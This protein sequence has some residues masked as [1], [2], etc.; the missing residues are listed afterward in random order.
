MEKPHCPKP[1]VTGNRAA[2]LLACLFQPVFWL[3][4]FC[5]PFVAKT[6]AAPVVIIKADD[7]RGPTP[8]WENFLEV[9]RAAMWNFG[10][11]AGIT[12]TGQI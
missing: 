5:S 10:I 11:M 7:F 12:S 9:S 4:M 8:A 1:Q 6:V 3:G 2:F